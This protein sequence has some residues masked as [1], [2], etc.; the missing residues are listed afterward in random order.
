MCTEL[1]VCFFHNIYIYLRIIFVCTE[2]NLSIHMNNVYISEFNRLAVFLIAHKPIVVW[3]L[4]MK[5]I[6]NNMFM[7]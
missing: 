2:K 1:N 7:I 3:F 4:F 6:T 5:K